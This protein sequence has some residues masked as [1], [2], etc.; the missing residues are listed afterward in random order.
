MVKKKIAMFVLAA[1]AALAL[2][3]CSSKKSEPNSSSTET[4]AAATP[5]PIQQQQQET[6]APTEEETETMPEPTETEAPEKTLEE[7]ESLFKENGRSGRLQYEII[8]MEGTQTGEGAFLSND[9]IFE[10]MEDGSSVAY[11]DSDGSY[12]KEKSG[13][14]KEGSVRFRDLLSPFREGNGVSLG[15]VSGEG[16]SRRYKLTLSDN[17]QVTGEAALPLCM[18][19]DEVE[20]SQSAAIYYL[21]D[22]GNLTRIDASL[23][24]T[25]VRDDMYVEGKYN[26]VFSVDG[27]SAEIPEV[28]DSVLEEIYPEYTPGILTESMYENSMFDVKIAGKDFIVFDLAT[29]ESMSNS[30]RESA[31][32][33]TAE[34][35]GNCEGGIISIS[36]TRFGI[37][38]NVADALQKYLRNCNAE[39]IGAAEN[40]QLNEVDTIR[41]AAD[42][43]GTATYTY[44]L[45]SG[46]RILF[47]TI[48]YK[49]AATVEEVLAHV[50]HSWEDPDWIEASWTL[51]G[52]Y[53]IR[54]PENYHIV[55]AESSEYYL[56]MKRPGMEEVNAFA[57]KT[58][59]VDD[60][61]VQ[62][63][64][65]EEGENNELISQETTEVNGSYAVY[66]VIRERTQTGEYITYELLQQAGDDVIKY[67]VV[68]LN[69]NENY[70][71]DLVSIASTMEMPQETTETQGAEEGIEVQ[72]DSVEEL[73]VQE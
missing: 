45:T 47:I 29:T 42:I 31:N 32:G 57:L 25:G 11:A 8:T 43:D 30:Y 27:I 13:G 67:F 50:Y 26:I 22:S 12:V 7:L 56:C 4:A 61:L 55:E 68:G 35:V 19:Y 49:D 52:M 18:W 28:P 3:G 58:V 41:C 33:Y 64:T 53:T 14:W 40:V 9:G 65:G 36:S 16:A 48:Y 44:C 21:D 59:T 24:F 15:E 1:T 38:G 46:S 2:A 20:I 69:E 70:M 63:A 10:L 51:D 23:A 34:A 37:S 73:F 60:Q 6:E 54:T 5:V 72:E 17:T 39:N 66:A 71:E 62:D